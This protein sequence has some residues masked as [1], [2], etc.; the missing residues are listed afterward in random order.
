VGDD[1][2]DADG[3]LVR[4][5]LAVEAVA[6]LEVAVVGEEDDGGVVAQ[7]LRV[8][9]AEERA[10]VVVE[11]LDH[12]V[13][14]PQVVA[15]LGR[16]RLLRWGRPG[17][18]GGDVWREHQLAVAPAGEVGLRRDER[19]VRRLDGEDE[20]EGPAAVALLGEE[21]L[22]EP[23][24]PVGLVAVDAARRGIVVDEVVR[25]ERIV[26]EL[27]GAPA[28]ESAT[29][30]PGDGREAALAREGAAAARMGAEQVPLADV[31]G[32]VAGVAELVGDRAL[33]GGHAPA[34]GGDE[35]AVGVL[36]GHQ[37]EAAG[38]ADRVGHAR[39]GEAQALGR[40]PVDVRRGDVGIA[41]AAQRV[42]P[43]LV[44]DDEEDVGAPAW[45]VHATRT[46]GATWAARRGR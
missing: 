38:D 19:G 46:T 21:A 34:D 1:E 28:L 3:L 25:V 7:S 9:E 45:G 41:V 8:Q 37:G 42:A 5:L 29:E 24:E 30:R 13:V 4:V 15:A 23:E 36:P 20:K 14:A 2:G 35:P 40:Q 22:G 12:G 17:G 18:R 33:G 11:V 27:E 10:D 31:R 16:S 32:L 26:A 6:S 43:E 39:V 44:A